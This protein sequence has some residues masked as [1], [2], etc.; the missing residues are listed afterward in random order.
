[1]SWR[2]KVK[3]S[4]RRKVLDVGRAAGD[5]VVDADDLVALRQEA[6]AQVRADEARPAGDDCSHD[7]I[8]LLG[9]YASFAGILVAS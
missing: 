3:R 1:M 8:L 2:M 7:D 9:R 5:E 4:L 6:L